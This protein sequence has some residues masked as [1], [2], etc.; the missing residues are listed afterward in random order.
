MRV[1]AGEAKGRPLQ[2]VPGKGTRPTT[3]KVK[4]AIF[5]MIGPYFN[6]GLALDLFAG[7]GGL[8]IEALSRGF[9]RA[10]FVDR[11]PRSVAVIHDNV[12]RTGMHARAE[13]YRNDAGRALKA[14]EKRRAALNL[15]LLDPPYAVRDADALMVEMD[16]RGLLA[17]AALVVVEHAADVRYA[18]RFGSFTTVNEANYGEITVTVY[19][20]EPGAKAPEGA[21]NDATI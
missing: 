13:V 17:P 20:Y 7:T 19:R 21:E 3:D 4:E 10:I 1:I 2:A 12:R 18:E 5:S 8:G 11:D 14:L 16:D 9:E 15:V 6:G